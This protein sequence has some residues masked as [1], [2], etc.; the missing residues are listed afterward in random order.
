MYDILITNGKIIDGTGN[1]GYIS[2]L[3]IKNGRIIK[4]EQN[5]NQEANIKIDASDQVVC[6]GFIDVHSHS[7]YIIP[8]YGGVDS[9]VFQGIT[10]AIVGNCGK[11]LA[12]ID[13]EQRIQLKSMFSM[14]NPQENL[15]W[16]TFSEYLEEM[17]KRS[18]PINTGFL[19]GMNNVV[20]AGKG[21]ENKPLQEEEFNKMVEIIENAMK[22][23]A[24]GM[25]MGLLYPP[26]SY[27]SK[28]EIIS[29]CKKMNPYHGII[30]AHIRSES[31]TVIGAV[32]EFIEIVSKSNI[33]G[34]YSHAKV[35]GNSFW[36][37]SSDII[38]LIEDANAKGLQIYYDSYPYIRSGDQIEGYLPPWLFENGPKHVLTHIQNPL[39]QKKIKDSILTGINGWENSI[40][41]NGFEN[42]YIMSPQSD[43]WETYKGKSIAEISSLSSTKDEWET[44]F[45]IVLDEGLG[46]Q[47]TC[48]DQSE[49]NIKK[50]LLNPLQMVGTD[51]V[52]A[53]ITDMQLHPR[54]YGTYPKLFR[55][56]VREEKI[57]SLEDAIR[58]CTA[59]PAQHFHIRERGS[60][61]VG[62]WADIV[63]FD[64]MIIDEK[65]SYNSRNQFP[66]GIS[67]V[68]VNG[69]STLLNGVRTENHPG[70]VLRHELPK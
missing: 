14:I 7:D 11:G 48:E 41:F 42:V 50:F 44:F 33:R 29:L 37:L 38:H 61:K 39:I 57:L 10:T 64:P 20:I 22:S 5:L 24:F 28:E 51:G 12:P 17:E 55:K 23:G 25:S 27:L 62:N 43:R 32:K 45:Q 59:L 69:I 56:Y 65:V 30:S 31:E 47:V 15:S 58:K 6:P 49:I 8:F 34:Q 19:L 60:I 36:D 70:H 40:G 26:H 54:Y 21:Y 16:S 9:S 66:V 3:A 46:L 63:V 18:C 4:I 13:D 35:M 53:P 67:N 68:I 52:G 1:S 2:D